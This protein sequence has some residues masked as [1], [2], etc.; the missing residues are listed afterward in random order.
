[1][2]AADAGTG[3]LPPWTP[4]S[5]VPLAVVGWSSAHA[6]LGVLESV[7]VP[8][9]QRD[10]LLARLSAV[11]PEVVLLST[12]DRTEV[13]TGPA[14]APEDLL[15]VVAR[16]CGQPRDPLAAG[17]RRLVGPAAVEHLFR[18][19]AG[20]ESRVVGEPEVCG[21]VRRAVRDARRAGT[22]GPVLTPPFDAAVR[23][24]RQ[25][26]DVSGLGSA[27]WSWGARAVASGLRALGP[28]AAPQVLVVGAGRLAGVVVTALHR[29]GL[30][31]VVV[32]RDVEAAGRLAGP[33]CARPWTALPGE[34]ALADLV[35]C[36]TSAPA[37][38]LSVADVQAALSVRPR[39][40]AVVDLAVPVD[41]DP[42]VRD[43][44]EV[45]LVLPADLADDDRTDTG[46][47]AAVETAAALVRVLAERYV[48][49]AAV[50][51]AGPLI[52]E[53]RRHVH[54]LC[55]AELLRAA[56]GGAPSEEL[57]QAAHL[58][59]VRLL[60]QPTMAARAAAATGD[61]AGLRLLA[62]ALGRPAGR[63]GWGAA[64]GPDGAGLT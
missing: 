3:G 31:P 5:S 18:V 16:E 30:A 53:F 20:L 41:V 63:T 13:Y 62:E 40:L 19:T 64:V 1:M 33:E 42:R 12:C 52:A 43:L 54:E 45:R 51:R 36:T 60:H 47:T 28:T 49:A 59:A 58:L 48:A 22:V 38:V 2:D 27:A 46:R 9:R 23:C 56:P 29:R 24:A 55:L 57:A 6:P 37:Q 11:D 4:V 61:A 44:P 35:C 17:S 10:G 32:A 34:L 8:Q 21:Q 15:E 50:R 14:T 7:A 25:V 39:A 26:H